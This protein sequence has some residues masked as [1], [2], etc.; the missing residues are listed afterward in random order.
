MLAA[1]CTLML[2]GWG[3]NN[4]SYREL[5]SSM[6][7]PSGNREHIRFLNELEKVS[8]TPTM[9]VQYLRAIADVDVRALLPQIKVP[10]LVLHCRGDRAAPCELGQEL[11]SGIAG[12]T[13]VP[14]EGENHLFLEDEPARKIFFEEVPR[15]LGDKRRLM[16]RSALKRHARGF[17]AATHDLHHIIE[18]YY[19][20]VAVVS[21]VIATATF[22]LSRF[23]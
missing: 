18:P 12:A 19:M 2:E 11:A 20:M 8:A 5:F 9:A 6:Y 3:G 14:M 7:V 16:T 21:A 10:A 22:I 1:M 17:R 4:E 23:T 15:F 13:F